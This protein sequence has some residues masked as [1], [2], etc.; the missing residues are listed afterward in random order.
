MNKPFLLTAASIL[1]LTAGDL[2]AA[3]PATSYSGR[4]SAVQIPKGAKILYNQNSNNTG[5]SVTSDNFT[6]G[7]SSTYNDQGADDFVIPKGKT[8]TITEVDVSGGYSVGPGPATSENVIFC[9]DK[10]GMPGKPVKKGTFTNLKGTDSR[11]NFAITLPAKGITLNAG[12]YWVS[13]IAN[14]DFA[15]YGLWAWD[16]NGVQHGNQAMWRNPSGVDHICQTWGTI[17]NCGGIG[18][19]FMF[20]LRGLSKRR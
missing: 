10:K 18:P 3:Q 6:S 14:M 8:W 12:T 9:K 7:S 1:A 11:G 5:A 13:V 20:D 15:A 2:A 4:F 19:D 17:E 16:V